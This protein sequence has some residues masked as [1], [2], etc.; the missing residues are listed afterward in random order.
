MTA[1]NATKVIASI[2]LA[3][4][5]AVLIGWAFDI[6]LLKSILPTWVTMKVTT[7][8][9]FVAAGVIQLFLLSEGK[10]SQIVVSTASFIILAELFLLALDIANI[11]YHESENAVMSVAPGFPSVGTIACFFLIFLAAYTK[12]LDQRNVIIQ[13]YSIVVL[14]A[15]IIA[16]VGYAADYP[17]LY[18]YLPGRSTAMAL[19]TAILFTMSGAN[20]YVI[21][22]FRG[23]VIQ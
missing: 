5:V 23:V 19:H 12:I 17:T 3:A 13:F 2:I 20:L 21:S 4:G 11:I 1:Y 14:I 7:A 10:R 15:G 6:Q 8:I 9:C 18:Y 22:L 16:I